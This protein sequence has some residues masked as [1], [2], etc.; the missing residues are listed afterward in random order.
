MNLLL[1]TRHYDM[2]NQRS[3][4]SEKYNNKLF[5]TKKSNLNFT[6]A[7]SKTKDIEVE[8]IVR[9]KFE[10]TLADTLADKFK[11]NNKIKIDLILCVYS[12]SIAWLDILFKNIKFNNV[13]I[14]IKNKNLLEDYSRILTLLNIK[15]RNISI[16]IKILPNVGSCDY[17]YLYHMLNNI[18]LSDNKSDICVF[19]KDTLD[20]HMSNLSKHSNLYN[21]LNIL[22][23]IY[24][25]NNINIIDNNINIVTKYRFCLRKYADTKNF[26]LDEWKPKSSSSFYTPYMLSEQRPYNKWLNNKFVSIKDEDDIEYSEGGQFILS[27]SRVKRIDVELLKSFLSDISY[28]NN[29]EESHYVERSYGILTNHLIDTKFVQ[30]VVIVSAL[31]FGHAIHSDGS[32]SEHTDNLLQDNFCHKI[33]YTDCYSTKCKYTNLGWNVIMVENLELKTHNECNL[34]AKK[35]KMQPHKLLEVQRLNPDFIIWMDFSRCTPNKKN[36]LDVIDSCN[37]ANK[38][39]IGM[40]NFCAGGIKGSVIDEY[41]ISCTQNR[42]QIQKNQIYDYILSKNNDK[43]PIVD[44]NKKF[45]WCT[46]L[47]YNMKNENTTNILDEWYNETMRTGIIQDQILFHFIYQQNK[48]SCCITDK[49]LHL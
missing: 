14:Y 5:S 11:I 10:T 41:E 8:S 17:V 15:Y 7:R 23:N 6:Y 38:S 16:I 21:L 24:N 37:I 34:H 4:L 36:I 39:I 19:E 29:N 33:L 48:T 30:N 12:T 18:I 43:I 28:S 31:I 1:D 49:M 40:Q 3:R 35:Y 26:S 32:M 44:E 27:T 20:I 9:S 22:K 42:Y 46:N 47:I 25:E 2:S 45:F 13:W